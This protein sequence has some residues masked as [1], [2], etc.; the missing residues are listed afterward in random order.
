MNWDKFWG[1]LFETMIV[2]SVLIFLG[3]IIGRLLV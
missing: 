3:Y 2:I 1:Q